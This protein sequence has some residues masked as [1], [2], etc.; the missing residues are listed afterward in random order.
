MKG[1]VERL[2][3]DEKGVDSCDYF[4]R[5]HCRKYECA[6]LL[7][8]SFWCWLTSLYVQ[9]ATSS[10]QIRWYSQGSYNQ[11]ASFHSSLPIVESAII[12]GLDLWMSLDFRSIVLLFPSDYFCLCIRVLPTVSRALH[13]S[14][15]Y[16][17]KRQVWGPVSIPVCVGLMVDKI[18]LWKIF[19]RF[20]GPFLLVSF[21][22][23]FII[24]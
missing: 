14:D 11:H 19:S 22:Q 16:S 23:C 8:V 18:S 2:E 17:L 3:G 7:L 6:S 13:G 10:N 20:F 5:I 15:S 1:V 12:S 24:I 9:T 4:L 21:H